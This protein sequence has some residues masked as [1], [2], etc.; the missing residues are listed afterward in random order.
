MNADGRLSAAVEAGRALGASVSLRDLGEAEMFG[1]TRAAEALE[2]MLS[3][4]MP[5]AAHRRAQR[6]GCEFN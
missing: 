5:L 2:K 6:L 4:L 3:R 1:A